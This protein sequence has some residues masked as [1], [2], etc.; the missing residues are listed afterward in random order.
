MAC[1]LRRSVRC[2][3]QHTATLPHHSLCPSHLTWHAWHRTCPALD[4]MEQMPQR[5]LSGS[6]GTGTLRHLVVL[7]SHGELHSPQPE[8]RIPRQELTSWQ[9]ERTVPR[10]AGA[11]RLNRRHLPARLEPRLYLRRHLAGR[12]DLIR[13]VLPD[14]GVALPAG[15]VGLQHFEGSL[16]AIGHE[17]HRIL[18]AGWRGRLAGD[19]QSVTLD[20]EGELGEGPVLGRGFVP[21][22]PEVDARQLRNVV[23]AEREGG[24]GLESLG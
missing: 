19:Q 6:D 21:R 15:G 14:E 11:W 22:A 13:I 10:R 1:L 3:P 2:L 7:P 12:L 9:T 18:T 8:L 4:E 17:L 16:E 23:E 20:G 24:G 5:T